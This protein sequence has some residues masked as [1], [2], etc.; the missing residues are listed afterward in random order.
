MRQ[1]FDECSVISR[2]RRRHGRAGEA[3]RRTRSCRL[4]AG[5]LLFSRRWLPSRQRVAV[6]LFAAELFAVE[7]FVWLRAA[8]RLRAVRLPLLLRALCGDWRHRPSRP[9]I[10]WSQS[11]ADTEHGDPT[12][13]FAKK[14][15]VPVASR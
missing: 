10:V 11:S 12:A 2:S 7:L 9:P 3:A 15:D 1:N 14:L 4:P 6:K 8:L 13:S 5:L